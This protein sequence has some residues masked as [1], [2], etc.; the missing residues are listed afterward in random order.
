VIHIMESMRNKEFQ[1][2]VKSQLM[3][4]HANKLN[5]SIRNLCCFRSE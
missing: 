1:Y 5:H 3:E 2:F 4:M